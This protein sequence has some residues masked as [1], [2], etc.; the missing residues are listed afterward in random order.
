MPK[1]GSKQSGRKRGAKKS[2]E[3]RPV[4]NQRTPSDDDQQS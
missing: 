3:E 4:K 1:G 2:N